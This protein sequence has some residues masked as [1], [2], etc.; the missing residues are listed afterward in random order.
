MW[1]V[2]PTRHF[3]PWLTASAMSF[4]IWANAAS[5][6]M[7]PTSTFSGS[8]RVEPIRRARTRGSNVWMS[9]G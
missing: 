4:S 2:P 7:A 3:A 6:I 5:E 9:L 1:R 8:S